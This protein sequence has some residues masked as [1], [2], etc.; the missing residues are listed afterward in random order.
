MTRLHDVE[1][2]IAGLRRR[3]A[4]AEQSLAD[5][6]G[7]LRPLEDE[8]RKMQAGVAL[9]VPIASEALAFAPEPQATT[10]PLNLGPKAGLG[11]GD[12]LVAIVDS[13]LLGCRSAFART[14]TF[15]WFVVVAWGFLIRGDCDGVTSTVRC[16][17]LAASEYHNLL[18][19]FHST[20]YSVDGLCRCWYRVVLAVLPRPTLNGKPLYVSDAIKVGKAGHKMPAVKTLHQESEDNTKPE[21]IRG[22]FWASISLLVGGV[23]A[24]FALPLRF[25]LQDGIKRSP[26]DRTS[27]PTKMAN[28]ITC[29]AL[30]P[31]YVVVDNYYAAVKFLGQLVAAGY[32]VISRLRS[33]AVAYEA[34]PAVVKRGRGRPRKYGTKV[35]LRT[36]FRNRRIFQHTSLPL[37]HDVKDIAFY[38]RDLFW[39]GVMVRIV[40]TIYQDG[41]RY[42]LICTDC[43][44]APE[45]IIQTYGLRFKIEVQFKELV[46]VL[47]GFAYH[48][49]MMTMPRTGS[50]P[51]N[52][53]LHRKSAEFRRLVF[54]KIEA[55]ERFVNIAAIA[56][57][58]LQT[59]ALL[60]RD[61]IWSHFPVWFRTL[62]TRTHPS[63]HVARITLQAALQQEIFGPH[64]ASTLLARILPAHQA[65]TSDPHPLRLVPPLNHS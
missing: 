16:F 11:G 43:T 37:Y 23:V 65:A 51:R 9:A 60:R 17:G 49:W 2:K 12:D 19:F 64:Q 41:K 24:P 50:R 52:L 3:R 63:E 5:L 25:Q 31:G 1:I 33:N 4:R 20:A 10:W 22:H 48:F 30:V 38:C 62:R 56:L 47:L 6:D 34:A 28:L 13:M 32:H 40:L 39:N 59:L 58:I 7:E 14:S 18:G 61:H 57:G 36:L 42:I 53:Y 55:Y 46:N 29:A 21:F 15:E 44:L 27:L 45:A 26:S 35:V 54:R 8:L